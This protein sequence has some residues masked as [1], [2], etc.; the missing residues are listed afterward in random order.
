MS[1]NTINHATGNYNTGTFRMDFKICTVYNKIL[2]PKKVFWC[3]FGNVY[4]HKYINLNV[5][6]LILIT[7][8]RIQSNSSE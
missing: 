4:M 1:A 6:K 2:I 3:S 7:F 5:H 8:L